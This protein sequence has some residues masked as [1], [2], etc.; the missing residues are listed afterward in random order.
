MGVSFFFWPGFPTAVQPP[1]LRG[2][3]A[4]KVLGGFYVFLCDPFQRVVLVG[5]FGG[6]DNAVDFNLEKEAVAHPPAAGNAN[7]HIVLHRNKADALICARFS[8]E[9]IHK[10]SLFAGVLVGNKA[11]TRA[12]G[13][14]GF[15]LLGRT[16][17]VDYLLAGA[18]A[19]TLKVIVDEFVVQGS[20]DAVHIK[21][22][23]C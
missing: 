7:R 5:P 22:E 9:E 21:T 4:D 13:G 23:K 11:E 1:V 16:L 14:D 8:A 15:H 20:C 12:F 2:V 17:F 6:H 18:L 3:F 19:G 10:Y